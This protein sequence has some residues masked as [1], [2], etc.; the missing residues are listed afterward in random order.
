MNYQNIKSYSKFGQTEQ[1]YNGARNQPFPITGPSGTTNVTQ[2]KYLGVGTSACAAAARLD[3]KQ[4]VEHGADKVVV[5]EAT[6]PLV[7]N[8]EGEDGKTGHRSAAEDD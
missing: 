3:S 5:E 7:S 2:T 1:N 8:E 6:A 4:V